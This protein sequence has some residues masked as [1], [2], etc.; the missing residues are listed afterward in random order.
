MLKGEHAWSDNPEA[1]WGELL[2]LKLN[3]KYLIRS[4]HELHRSDIDKLAPF[5]H[6]LFSMCLSFM[7]LE[8]ASDQISKKRCINAC[9]VRLDIISVIVADASVDAG[10]CRSCIE[11]TQPRHEAGV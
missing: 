3:G 2:L 9:D 1:F 6:M 10:M 4:L 7:D 8:D 11:H 5:F